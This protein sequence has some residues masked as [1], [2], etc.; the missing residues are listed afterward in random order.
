MQFTKQNPNL[1]GSPH[2]WMGGHVTWMGAPSI[3]LCTYSSILLLVDVE[4]NLKNP[5][6]GWAKSMERGDGGCLFTL[7]SEYSLIRSIF[8]PFRLIR[9]PS[10]VKVFDDTV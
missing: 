7:D 1:T 3:D 8:S 4:E 2:S 9:P 6:V 5:R 10:C